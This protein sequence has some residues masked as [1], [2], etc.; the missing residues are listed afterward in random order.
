MSDPATIRTAYERSAKAVSLKPAIGQYTAVTKIRVRDGT[1]CDIEHGDWKFT[2][3]VGTQQGG[4]NAGPGP[5]ILERAALG[6]CLAI[7]YATWAALLEVPIAGLE[8]EVESDVDARGMFG[9]GDV[10]PGFSA[11]RY[12]VS[13]TSP[14]SREEILHVLDEADRHSPVLD[15]FRRP[16]PIERV[17]EITE[18]GRP[19]TP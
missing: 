3:D 14:A 19:A 2:A 18:V 16:I 1:T 5:G 11:I 7:G 8:V 10:P 15:D 13:I 9:T 6:S 17:V 4:N 12:R